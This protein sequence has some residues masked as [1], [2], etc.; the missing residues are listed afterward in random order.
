[1]G[2]T[3]L[4]ILWVTGIHATTNPTK[5]LIFIGRVEWRH[6]PMRRQ[7]HPKLPARTADQLTEAE[8][9]AREFTSADPE[10]LEYLSD[11]PPPDEEWEVEYT[12]DTK[13]REV[14]VR[15]VLCKYLNHYKGVVL[16]YDPSGTRRLVGHNCA[17]NC[18]GIE[19][20][21]ELVEFNAAAERQ[22]CVRRRRAVFAGIPRVTEAFRSLRERS[23]VR[24]HDSLRRTWR[25]Q[26]S[27]SLAV[28]RRRSKPGRAADRGLRCSR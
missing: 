26:F 16:R 5:I 6:L 9:L 24:T 4:N 12:Y 28:D 10:S 11:D 1:M 25:D 2:T 17:F 14:K 20:D 27:N 13:G 18:Y 22:S 19:F 21:T 15:C 3:R 23:A 7:R 8:L